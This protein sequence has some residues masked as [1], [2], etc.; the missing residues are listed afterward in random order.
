M[1]HA[2][3][4]YLELLDRQ[5]LDN[6]GR[7]VGK[8]D[9]L[10]LEERDDGRVYVT[11]LLSGPGALGPRLGGALDTLVTSAWSRLSGRTEPARV[12]W[13]QVASVGAAVRLA[14][15][16]TTVGVDGFETW[17]R[18]R[19]IGAIPGSKVLPK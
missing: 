9:D 13:S 18:D 6:D 12:E 8:V 11:A 16:R 5:I 7:M 4:A 15:G 1:S 3:D 10:E 2:M 17:M 14:V 19:V